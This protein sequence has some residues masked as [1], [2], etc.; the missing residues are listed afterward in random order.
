MGGMFLLPLQYNGVKKSV[1]FIATFR[2]L[3]I[4]RIP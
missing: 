3:N 2:L 1:D 4:L